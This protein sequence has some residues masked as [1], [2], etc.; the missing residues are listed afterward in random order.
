MDAN[1]LNVTASNLWEK[2]DAIMT[3][4]VSK[5]LMKIK[6]GVA[7]ALQSRHVPYHILCKLRTCEKLDT[8][9]LTTLSQLEA[10]VGLRGALLKREPQLES[11]LRS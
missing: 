10:K 5:N 9:N 1:K 8:D 7:E 6:H 3:D 2:I 4:T 11:F